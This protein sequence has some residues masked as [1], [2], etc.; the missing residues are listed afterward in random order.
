M[1]GDRE[2][3]H[4]RARAALEVH[5]PDEARRILAPVVAAD[6]SD[7]VA[8]AILAEAACA[9]GNWAGAHDLTRRATVAAPDDLAV[10][11]ACADVA[12]NTDDLDAAYYWVDR[13]LRIDPDDV[14]ALALMGLVEIS[15][16]FIPE[17]VTYT[18]E[19]LERRPDD[20]DMLVGYGWALSAA[21]RDGEST[22]AY[23]QALDIDPH[24]V[25]A[26]N[27]LAVARLRCGDLGRASTLLTSALA[28]DPRL[29]HARDNLDV[30]GRLARLI[31]L[32]RL[33]VGTV[34]AAAL[35][36]LHVPF[37]GLLLLATLLWVGRSLMTLAPP[38]RARLGEA[39]GWRDV[40]IAVLIV[41]AMPWAT[42]LVPVPPRP[43]TIF[44]WV[45]VFAAV[46]LGP[47]LWRRVVVALHLR[48]IGH[49][50]PRRF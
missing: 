41:V 11:L 32:S 23:L 28:L 8:L 39:V 18:R 9:E 47:L 5:R 29:E 12:R 4:A 26:M 31:L 44:A 6:P 49:R 45:V 37:S 20:P 1:N 3:A 2:A 22:A 21:G 17:A 30:V 33:G 24:H 50:L 35:A 25:H 34:G 46:V 10:L 19:A 14:H 40:L 42:G 38:V 15:R 48:A 13:A 7:A 16:D 36:Y 27:N 43:P